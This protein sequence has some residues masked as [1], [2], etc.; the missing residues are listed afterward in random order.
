M[1]ARLAVPVLGALLLAGC[2][3]AGLNPFPDRVDSAPRDFG[4]NPFPPAVN[5]AGTEG[6]GLT[7]FPEHVD[8]AGRRSFGLD[9][10]PGGGEDRGCKDCPGCDRCRGS[11][12][13]AVAKG[14]GTP[15][16]APAPA[17]TGA[18]AGAAPVVPAKAPEP[19]PAPPAERLRLKFTAGTSNRYRNTM[20]MSISMPAMGEMADTQT[21]TEMEMTQKVV[22]LDDAGRGVVESTFDALAFTMTNVMFGE[23]AFDTRKPETIEEFG[24]SPI[25]Q[26]QPAIMELPKLV[27]KK[28]TVH[29]GTD[30]TVGESSGFD[31]L[32]SMGGMGGGFNPSSVSGISAAFP[33]DPVKVGLAWDFEISMPAGPIGSVNTKGTMT[34]TAW[35][36]VTRIAVVS[37]AATMS[38]ALPA[39]AKEGETPE[40][41]EEAM[42]AE[43]LS[44][45]RIKEGE[46]KSESTYDLARGVLLSSKGTSKMVMEMPNP[47]MEGEM[48]EMATTT[49]Q[50]MELL[51]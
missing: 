8:T 9:P 25:A 27:G 31:S 50:S 3:S 43:M 23:L 28:V 24:A 48:M 5:P 29:M 18:S 33:D 17:K 16:A 36:P 20:E 38:I 6:C 4:L 45:L 35:D 49:S 32:G 39:A 15:P 1:N 44:K 22:S 11:K 37:A 34:V 21:K 51:K 7:P 10:F 14:T 41:P 13:V 2:S 19:P 40:N 26:M 42:Q 46:T 30:G 47:M 12:A